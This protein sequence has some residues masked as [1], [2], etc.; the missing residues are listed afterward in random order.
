MAGPERGKGRLVVLLG[1][2]GVGKTALAMALADRWPAEI[3]SA[4]S[5][6]VYRGMDIGTAKPTPDQRRLVPHHL[7]DVVD[8]DEPFDAS[9]YLALARGAVDRL[10]G[11]GK[12]VFV[13][14]GTGLYLRALLGGLITGPGADEALRRSLKEEMAR[15]GRPWLHEKL[16]QQDDRAAARINPNDG[17]RVIR[18]LEVLALTGRSIIDCQQEHRFAERPYEVLKIGLALDRQGL[19]DRIDR[20]TEAMVEQGFVAEV[21]GLLAR[22]YGGE[23]KPMQSLGY[24]HMVAYL[25]GQG[26]LAQAVR[27]IQ[28][29]TRRY[30]RRQMTWFSADREISWLAPEAVDAA[31]EAVGRVL[32]R[33]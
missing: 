32:D 14:G 4:D 17:V 1:P 3:V 30:A 15:Q 11:E 24:R 6:Q 2:T 20:R 33:R 21:Q 7:I 22:G 18:A 23:L 13:V 12:N 16:R 10:Q 26:D 28:R 19:D 27:L 5:M 9:R 29:D 25:S 8:P 31:T